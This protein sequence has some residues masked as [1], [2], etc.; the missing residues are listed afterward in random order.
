M[1]ASKNM[2]TVYHHLFSTI[3]RKSILTKI[4]PYIFELSPQT[5][6]MTFQGLVPVISSSLL[7]PFSL[8]LSRF[9]FS[10]IN[11]INLHN[12]TTIVFR[13]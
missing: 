12:I 4:D 9:L 13:S 1:Q 11:D 5:I 7:N 10:P 8:S 2:M 3:T 6:V